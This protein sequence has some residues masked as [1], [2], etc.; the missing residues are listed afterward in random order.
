MKKVQAGFKSIARTAAAETAANA[1]APV[2][3]PGTAN[4][5]LCNLIRQVTVFQIKGNQGGTL[6]TKKIS[7]PAFSVVWSTGWEAGSDRLLTVTTPFS[8]KVIAPFV[9]TDIVAIFER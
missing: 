7:V 8:S 5:G 9:T 6:I 3:A 2:P 1:P 4:V